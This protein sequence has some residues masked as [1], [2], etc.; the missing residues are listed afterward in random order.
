MVDTDYLI[1]GQG[2]AGTILG[3]TLLEN[4][5][6][7]HIIDNNHES[8][9]SKVA[10]GMWNPIVFRKLNK[11]WRVEDLLP[12]MNRFYSHWEQ[13]LGQKFLH[14]KDI[15]RIFPGHEQENDWIARSGDENYANYLRDDDNVELPGIKLRFKAGFGLVKQSGYLEVGSFLEAARTY[16]TEL[17]VYSNFQLDYQAIQLTENTVSIEGYSAKKMIFCEGSKGSENPWFNTLPF[18]NTKGE[19]LTIQAE[20]LTSEVIPNLG[21]WLLPIGAN[22]YKVGATFDWSDFSLDVTSVAKEKLVRELEQLIEVDYTIT[23]HQAGIRPTMLD[24]RPV[25]G[26]HS[27]YPQLG[28][29]NGLGTKGV[30]NAPWTAKQ[31]SDF[32][33]SGAVL[34]DDISINRFTH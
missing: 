25:V 4:G 17:G 24:R 30:M 29:F 33:V 32:L 27:I 7:V 26:Q 10:A 28:I 31:Y 12:E 34:P 20:G 23:N 16:F 15:A 8:A 1:V 18:N 9:A 5:Q 3:L 21:V 6:K 14:H 2:L 11:S 19:L 13:K 22:N